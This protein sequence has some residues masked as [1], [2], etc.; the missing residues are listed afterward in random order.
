MLRLV[1]LAV[2]PIEIQKLKFY[3]G[4]F[5]RI[6]KKDWAFRKK[7]KNSFTDEVVEIK[8]IPILSPP[9]YPSVDSGNETIKGKFYQPELQL[10]RL[11][12]EENVT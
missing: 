5:G 3:I 8:R 11:P 12:L 6:V 10:V 7:Y 9:T 4:D 1:S 2:K